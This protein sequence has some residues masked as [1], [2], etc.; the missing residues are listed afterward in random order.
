MAQRL[1]NPSKVRKDPEAF[2][3]AALKCC[4][5]IDEFASLSPSTP[6]CQPFSDQQA[7]SLPFGGHFA[8]RLRAKQVCRWASE[9]LGQCAKKA[10]K[11]HAS[12]KGSFHSYALWVAV[13]RCLE[14]EDNAVE[15]V[16][17]SL[18]QA[19]TQLATDW[20]LDQV[21]GDKEKIAKAIEKLLSLIHRTEAY[22]NVA[23][24]ATPSGSGLSF[25]LSGGVKV[26]LGLLREALQC[27]KKCRGDAAFWE[28]ICVQ[29]L[30]ET[31]P[32]CKTEEVAS[33]VLQH[34]ELYFDIL[35]LLDSEEAIAAIK[36]KS[37]GKDIAEASAS[38]SLIDEALR[39]VQD[40]YFPPG[41]LL[42]QYEEWLLG[43][44]GDC[45]LEISTKGFAAFLQHLQSKRIQKQKAKKAVRVYFLESTLYHGLAEDAPGA[46]IALPWIAHCFDLTAKSIRSRQRAS[47]DKTSGGPL[48]CTV[49]LGEQDFSLRAKAQYFM[50]ILFAF[51]LIQRTA[52]CVGK[53][54]S[55][56]KVQHSSLLKTFDALHLLYFVVEKRKLY[57]RVE[58]PKLHQLEVMTIL[59]KQLVHT[60]PLESIESDEDSDSNRWKLRV[61]GAALTCMMQMSKVDLRIVEK[62]MT[63]IWCLF[64]LSNSDLH[65]LASDFDLLLSPFISGRDEKTMMNVLYQSIKKSF[66]KRKDIILNVLFFKRLAEVAGDVVAISCPD[67]ID[68]TCDLSMDM[69]ANQEE[70]GA[71][72]ISTLTEVFCTLL[73][74]L[75]IVRQNAHQCSQVCSAIL[76]RIHSSDLWKD[77]ISTKI[78]KKNRPPASS[79]ACQTA[80]IQMYSSFSRIVVDCEMIGYNGRADDADGE[81]VTIAT[82]AFQTGFGEFA[83]MLM[84]LASRESEIE[85]DSVARYKFVCCSSAIQYASMESLNDTW[86]SDAG[87]DTS[88]FNRES[89]VEGITDIA[90]SCIKSDDKKNGSVW[91]G[92]TSCVGQSNCSIAMMHLLASTSFHWSKLMQTVSTNFEDFTGLVL[93]HASASRKSKKTAEAFFIQKKAAALSLIER[94]SQNCNRRT[95]EILIGHCV[96]GLFLHLQDERLNH[97]VNDRVKKCL[98]SLGSK[99]KNFIKQMESLAFKSHSDASKSS[100]KSS[101][102]SHAFLTSDSFKVIL[103]TLELC[104]ENNQFA[105]SEPHGI[106]MYVIAIESVIIKQMSITD[107]RPGDFESLF[108]QLFQTRKC[109]FHCLM[110]G[111]GVQE[112]ERPFIEKWCL[113]S[114]SH[115]L[116]AMPVEE[117]FSCS[118]GTFSDIVSLTYN[119]SL[120]TTPK[121][122]RELYK[123]FIESTE[124]DPGSEGDKHRI[125]LL[126]TISYSI[127]TSPSNPKYFGDTFIK[128]EEE[129]VKAILG[130]SSLKVQM[131]KT[132]KNKRQ[133]VAKSHSLS[134][135]IGE[136][137]YVESLLETYIEIILHH[138]NGDKVLSSPDELPPSLNK[139]FPCAQSMLL[140]IFGNTG[141]PGFGQR[142]IKE[143][144][145]ILW[146]RLLQFIEIA[147]G[148]TI[149]RM[150]CNTSALRQSMVFLKL[151]TYC[152][153]LLN[154]L[155]S[156]R[157]VGT[158]QDHWPLTALECYSDSSLNFLWLRSRTQSR[159][160]LRLQS[161]YA[162]MHTNS[163][164]NNMN[165]ST[166]QK[167]LEA[168][169][170]KIISIVAWAPSMKL[171]INTIGR[172]LS[173]PLVLFREENMG[174]F[175]LAQQ[176]EQIGW[177]SRLLH[178]CIKFRGDQ[179]RRSAA[180]IVQ[181]TCSLQSTLLSL[182]YKIY[183]S[184]SMNKPEDETEI[185]IEQSLQDNIKR[186]ASYLSDLYK[187]LSNQSDNFGKY[188]LHL[189]SGYIMLKETD[190][191][192][193]GKSDISNMLES[194]VCT[195][196]GSCPSKDLKHLH[197]VFLGED[198]THKYL[199]K[200][201]KLH[202]KYELHHKYQGKK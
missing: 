134:M 39:W 94:L 67:L 50:A 90:L 43:I 115:V 19:L 132:G 179:C 202:K 145:I 68:L 140:S 165:A 53:P 22:S 156:K 97:I 57:H 174:R 200:L 122:C 84:K 46:A 178:A 31:R 170:A 147:I 88:D 24:G 10:G 157:L 162:D 70:V 143:L 117:D 101:K 197:M 107:A 3:R 23:S 126:K 72:V 54:S 116:N 71:Q 118:L 159:T 25:F 27:Y 85:S 158:K 69:F 59:S 153:G 106:A 121:Q 164:L 182:E 34:E 99:K 150:V 136:S 152:E 55:N 141:L 181:S 83:Q 87:A 112:E 195:L 42:L 149:P 81:S 30:R 98:G 180:L 21:L 4:E 154:E 32:Y 17:I 48:T 131:K 45:Q 29:I 44:W 74:N 191:M 35:F 65:A 144:Q 28:G 119:V 100:Q 199:D 168:C 198:K 78:E 14:V 12:D 183:S 93:K 123:E 151:K 163:M 171:R 95:H 194:G 63:Y 128:F 166:D 61:C 169:L 56:R 66:V 138:M 187:E 161:N 173:L 51:H 7:P 79:R 167:E 6:S 111:F 125:Y 104:L 192:A 89:F 193:L 155:L 172:L 64:W 146:K 114:I 142:Q 148:K 110:L 82:N 92:I 103:Y 105:C 127:R 37:E 41:D 76:E 91:N 15:N 36:S 109:L 52:G 160:C 40:F 135:H 5:E 9:S 120:T 58:D 62:E 201:K 190:L 176:C 33:F 124:E 13:S 73:D 185:S 38:L 80:L 177:C 47:K 184:T 189:L 49:R 96:E 133:K 77:L 86:E 20:K 11:P 186:A 108:Q 2:H 175:G 102:A 137:L 26:A 18:L 188:L 129:V 130:F 113:C 1:P 60:L 16:T 196:I 75:R 8:L 139:Y